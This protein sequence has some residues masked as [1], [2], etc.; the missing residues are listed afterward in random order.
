M[1]NHIDNNIQMDVI[2]N[3][4][5][6]LLDLKLK[7]IQQKLEDIENCM[8]ER[9]NHH[10]TDIKHNF[11]SCEKFLPDSENREQQGENGK[12]ENM[13]RHQKLERVSLQLFVNPGSENVT[14]TS[15]SG[16]LKDSK[17]VP[18]PDERGKCNNIMET[19]NSEPFVPLALVQQTRERVVIDCRR[20]SSC[21]S[22]TWC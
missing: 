1:E 17:P 20:C 2:R 18:M 16:N 15:P 12:L 5:S 8:H 19:P 21:S 3:M 9:T 7:P 22:L 13:S 10:D 14:P 11:G 6:Q 4:L